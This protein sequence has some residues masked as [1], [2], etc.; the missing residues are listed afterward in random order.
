MTGTNVR[1]WIHRERLLWM[2]C[3]VV[4]AIWLARGPAALAEGPRRLLTPSIQRSAGVAAPAGPVAALGAP[5]PWP[6]ISARHRGRW[7]GY[8]A[9]GVPTYP[10]GYFGAQPQPYHVE[11]SGYYGNPPQWSVRRGD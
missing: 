3:C 11:H 9:G 1:R 10:W 6:S 8:G 2:A 7:T 5:S 4:S